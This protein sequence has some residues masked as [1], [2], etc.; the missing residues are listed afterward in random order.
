MIRIIT[1]GATYTGVSFYNALIEA[2][3]AVKSM[4][5]FLMWLVNF[6]TYEVE[7]ADENGDIIHYFPQLNFDGDDDDDF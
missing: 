7:I 6:C 3:T 2:Y 5:M 1:L 4:G